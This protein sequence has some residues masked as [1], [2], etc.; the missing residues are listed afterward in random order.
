MELVRLSKVCW[1]LISMIEADLGAVTL[2]VSDVEVAGFLSVLLPH[3]TI[4]IETIMAA[5]K[6]IDFFMFL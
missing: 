2:V 6:R 4:V 1:S 5:T 3:A